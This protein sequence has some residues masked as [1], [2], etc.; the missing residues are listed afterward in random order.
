MEEFLI[1]EDSPE[2]EEKDKSLELESPVRKRKR[3]KKGSKSGEIENMEADKGD[4]DDEG[5]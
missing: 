1:R 4:E 5:C 3:V 2:R